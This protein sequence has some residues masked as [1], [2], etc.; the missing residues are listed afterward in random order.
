MVTE[1]LS[2][3][4]NEKNFREIN[5]FQKF[6][7]YFNQTIYKLYD[8]KRFPIFISIGSIRLKTYDIKDQCTQVLDRC[9]TEKTGLKIY[10][11]IKEIIK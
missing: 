8:I 4:Y 5:S 6:S 10:K 9:Y 1:Q 2:E 11:K 3:T 7:S